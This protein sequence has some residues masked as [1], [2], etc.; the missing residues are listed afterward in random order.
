MARL[1]RVRRQLS[2]DQLAKRLALPRS[3]IYYWVRDLPLR[4]RSA[5]EQGTRPGGVGPSGAQTG[6]VGVAAQ[7]GGVGAGGAGSRVARA[8]R[9]GAYEQ[10][11]RSYDDL[12]AQPTFRDFMSVY[13]VDGYKRDRRKVAL[14]SADPDVMRLARRWIWRLSDR[15]PSLSV[16]YTADQS[17]DELRRFW[18]DAVGEELRSIRATHTADDELLGCG[19]SARPVHGVLTAAVQDSV[20]RARMQAWMFR[21]REEWP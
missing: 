5:A 16:R 9:A 15:S 21:T 3:T 19:W 12:I 2:V 10:A 7:V 20:L 14:S 6:G 1:M 8:K 11:L 4:E 18:S 13:I 17:R